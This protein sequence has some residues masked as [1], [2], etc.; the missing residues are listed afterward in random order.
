MTKKRGEET[1]QALDIHEKDADYINRCYWAGKYAA[2]KLGW[3]SI[4]CYQDDEMLPEETIKN[5][6]LEEIT[7]LLDTK[8]GIDE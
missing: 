6:L 7:L 5:M 2:N 1:G 8:G 4:Q 3:K